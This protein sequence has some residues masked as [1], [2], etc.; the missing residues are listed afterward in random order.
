[1]NQVT[2][3]TNL[4]AFRKSNYNV[5]R[6]FSDFLGLHGKLVIK[7]MVAGRIVP[8][9]PEKSA[10]GAFGVKLGNKEDQTSQVG[11]PSVTI[12]NYRIT[13]QLSTITLV[14]LLR[15]IFVTFALIEL[16]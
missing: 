3:K 13:R 5:S 15:L 10:I 8:P 6:R 14:H 1:M 7:H 12:S 16:R 9:P 2:T 11:F 4:P